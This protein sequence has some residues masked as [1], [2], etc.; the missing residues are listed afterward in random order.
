MAAPN[1][2]ESYIEDLRMRGQE[3]KAGL[4]WEIARLDRIVRHSFA[5]AAGQSGVA[6]RPDAPSSDDDAKTRQAL[7]TLTPRERQVLKRIAEGCSTKQVAATLGIKFKTAACHRHRIMQKL[8]VHETTSLVRIAI[9]C[10]I[11][12]L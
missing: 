9:R 11:V 2:E 12:N 6:A 3:L 7:R 10:G 8:G 5:S 4:E 1:S